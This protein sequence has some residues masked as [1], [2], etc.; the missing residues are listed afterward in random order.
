[1]AKE[2]RTLLFL[3]STGVLIGELSDKTSTEFMDLSKFDTKSVEIDEG[4]GD[5]YYGDYTTGEVRNHYEKPVINESLV[6]YAANVKILNE[7]PI[8]RQI[9]IIVEMLNANESLVKT[10]KFTEMIA[11]LNAQRQAYIEKVAGFSDPNAFHWISE[12]EEQATKVAKR[13]VNLL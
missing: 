4:A 7:Y 6:K 8:H 9:N 10:E 11:F 5:Y 12:D 1:M 2:T 13:G 3:K